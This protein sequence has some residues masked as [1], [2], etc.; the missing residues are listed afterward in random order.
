MK[1]CPYCSRPAIRVTCGRVKC[2]EKH[3]KK[4]WSERY[5]KL[6]PEEKKIYNRRSHYPSTTKKGDLKIVEIEKQIHP[7]NL[8]RLSGDRFVRAV[9]QILRG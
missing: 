4:L 6:S 8:Q 9:N 2:V 7:I 3:K 5:G 1:T